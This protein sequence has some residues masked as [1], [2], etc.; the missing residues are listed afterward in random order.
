MRLAWRF[1]TC[2]ELCLCVVVYYCFLVLQFVVG[3]GGL[4]RTARGSHWC[5]PAGLDAESLLI[6][7]WW[8]ARVIT[9]ARRWFSP[10]RHRGL[11]P[12]S[13][14]FARASVSSFITVFDAE[15]VRE[16]AFRLHQGS[17][18]SMFITVLAWWW[19]RGLLRLIETNLLVHWIFISNWKT[20]I[21]SFYY[22]F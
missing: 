6:F 20:W 11:F 10:A 21:V 15:G 8:D 12:G 4:L 9:V 5:L 19:H 17:C 18:V 13:F 1:I 3:R 22:C 16:K 14:E 7:H 2:A